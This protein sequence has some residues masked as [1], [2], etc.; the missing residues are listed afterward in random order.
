MVVEINPAMSL[1]NWTQ[2][3]AG[4]KF[5]RSEIDSI[6]CKHETPSRAVFGYLYRQVTITLIIPSIVGWQR[7]AMGVYGCHR[8]SMSDVSGKFVCAFLDHNVFPR[9]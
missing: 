1:K 7:M 4:E 9:N 2:F 8:M 6:R 5:T 3:R